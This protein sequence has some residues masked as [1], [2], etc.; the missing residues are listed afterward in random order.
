MFVRKTYA[1][2]L[3]LYERGLLSLGFLWQLAERDEVFAAY[4]RKHHVA[5]LTALEMRDLVRTKYTHALV[6]VWSGILAGD[7]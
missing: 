3:E 1:G 6:D 2:S 5:P 4:L 7:K